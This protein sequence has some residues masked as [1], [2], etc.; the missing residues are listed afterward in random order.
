M[1]RLEL[2]LL[3]VPRVSIDGRESTF[4]TRKALAL[5]AYLAAEGGMHHR[6]KLAELLWPHSPDGR[7]RTT[8]RSA[9]ASVRRELRD[10]APSSGRELLRVEGDLL[11]LEAG[12]GLAMDLDV[13]RDASAAARASRLGASRGARPGG[14]GDG[15][16]ISSLKEAD[17]TYGGEFMEGFRLEDA[18]EFDLWMEA[19]RGVWRARV[20]EV[21]GRLAELE[22]EAGELGAAAGTAERRVERDPSEEAARVGLMQA[23]SAA[24]DPG[25]ALA[26]Y[27]EYRSELRDVGL[28]PQPETLTAS[29]RARAQADRAGEGRPAP[30][31]LRM[32]FVGREAE[33]GALV[34]EY[35]AARS[36][37]VRSAVVLGEAGIGKTRLAEE[38][39]GWAES[40]GADVL[41]GR[42]SQTG[43]RQAYEA[44]VD[45]LRPRLER[46]RAPD[47][48]LEDRWLAELS[49][50]VPEL[51]DRYP[52]LPPPTS[53]E[54]SSQAA[55]FEAVARLGAA[56]AGGPSRQDG[57]AEAGGPGEPLVVFGDDLQWADGASLD[58]IGYACRSW[59]RGGMPVLVLFTVREEGL[60]NNSLGG[61]LSSLERELAVR[62]LALSPMDEGNVH[63]LLR[64]IA[65]P[66]GSDESGPRRGDLESVGRWLLKE[67][68]GN[69]L[70]LVQI[71][72]VLL[73]RGVL[74]E[75][76][77]PDGR[78]EIVLSEEGF[79]EGSLR[80]LVPAGLRELILD[81][82]RPLPTDAR[83]VLAAG[84]VLGRGFGFDELLAVAG[85][86]EAEGIAALDA[87]VSARLLEEGA[88][89]SRGGH[90]GGAYSFAHEKIREVV[91]TEAGEARRGVFHRRALEYLKE[92]GASASELARH[93][94]GAKAWEKA[95]RYL[96]AAAE[97]AMAVFA[98][99]DAVS[100]YERARELLEDRPWRGAAR[101][102]GV[103]GRL[104]LYG[105]LA[106]ASALVHDLARAQ[107]AYEKM[108]A[109]ARE[110]G[111]RE[112]EWEALHGLGTLV[113][114]FAV[115]PDGDELLR[116]V[117][118]REDP[119]STVSTVGVT[120]G[121]H[122]RTRAS[123]ATHSPRGARRYAERALR[124]ARELGREDLVLRSEFG[125][126]LA[127]CWDGM[128]KES[129]FHMEAALSL[130]ATMGSGKTE[131][132]NP[133]HLLWC[134]GLA[135]FGKA[136][137][138][139]PADAF[140]PT[141]ALQGYWREAATLSNALD[142]DYAR[143]QLSYQG[144]GLAW[145]GEYEEAIGTASR[146]LEA[147]RSLGH[148]Q[149]A[150]LSLTGL[151]DAHR[152]TFALEEARSAYSEMFDWVSLP[153]LRG[154]VHAKLCAVAV[155]SGEWERAHAHALEAITSEEESF[156]PPTH[157]H[158]HHDIEA[159]LRGGDTELAREILSGFARRVG[160]G[161]GYFRVAYL[162]SAAVFERWDGDTDRTLSLLY[163]A[164]GLAERL[165]L[166]GEVWQVAADLG[167]THEE[168][169]ETGPS[170]RAF[171][172]ASVVVRQ[173]APKIPEG[174]LR[175]GFL[176][177]PQ[178]R[179]VLEKARTQGAR[180][181]PP[182]P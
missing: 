22:S 84:A 56:L 38:F 4:R 178:V 109:V 97:G 35:R 170:E 28:E 151:G 40:Q 161:R 99:G 156:L 36:G 160:R 94:L 176:A 123:E 75:R 59:A 58:A 164:L 89:A 55:L 96:L 66:T 93:A 177:A 128:W 45:A 42:T 81:K 47:D 90:P 122:E 7:G 126:G 37:T 5:L 48:L 24:G 144:M 180:R 146:G 51:G 11:G 19:Q 64:L 6:D 166:P 105:G 46:E 101:G 110:A 80:G 142:T 32:P 49:R 113:T 169:G 68:E 1:G 171:G 155:L 72:G 26:A 85:I 87:L 15:N 135:A 13:L 136:L 95:F 98:A 57:T 34:A 147:S 129:A 157:L 86:G 39:L 21:L 158:R 163:E 74:A 9:L 165:G 108:L 173:L 127:C 143:A 52:D 50:I 61:W 114:G 112:A 111:D 29:I 8:L 44:L 91:Y 140:G 116:G 115:G 79:D 167:E 175:E 107:E 121:Q 119:S 20:G 60:R 141:G 76:A 153:A 73:E 54:A 62:R 130:Y 71:V 2:R 133:I 82:L 88:A 77:G 53:D 83:D 179:R 117:G 23:R 145:A 69:P 168:R 18:P 148:P 149:L 152:A 43:G 33:F 162:R 63:G 106:R 78:R 14:E 16:L 12:P 139:G 104:R 102:E 30:G 67:S 100:R 159:L 27:E 10:L 31:P 103:P 154:I 25:G 118:R 70:F 174:E 182:V 65:G 3:G 92:R 120:R 172:R 137:A 17:A 41:R 132:Q 131:P 124:L 134:K 150:Y 138:D 181:G 125:L